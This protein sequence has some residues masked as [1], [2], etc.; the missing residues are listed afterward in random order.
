MKIIYD[1]YTDENRLY[2][3]LKAEF[4]KHHRLIIAVDFDDTIF[5]AHGN[6][7]WTYSGVVEILLRWQDNATIIC[8]TSSLPERYDFIR[9]VFTAHGIRLDDINANAPGIAPRGPKIYANIYLDDRSCGLSRGLHVLDR[10]AEE[11]GF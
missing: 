2:Q 5:N 8:W 11:K 6:P 10:L 9:S 4:E 7:G 1:P 3:R